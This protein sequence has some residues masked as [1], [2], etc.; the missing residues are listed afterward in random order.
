MSSVEKSRQKDQSKIQSLQ[1]K[2]GKVEKAH[3]DYCAKLA[4]FEKTHGEEQGELRQQIQQLQFAD[5][6]LQDEEIDELEYRLQLQSNLFASL[7][8]AYG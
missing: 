6:C 8:P 1:G 4:A 3:Q 5:A 7:V 2:L